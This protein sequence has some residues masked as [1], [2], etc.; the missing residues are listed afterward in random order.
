[1]NIKHLI[2]VEKWTLVLS[3]LLVAVAVLV[4][5]RRAAFGISIG[6]GLMSLNA[7]ALRRIGQRAFKTFK[8]PNVAILLLNVKMGI[9][10]ALVWA[11]IH[12]LRVDPVAFIV[13][14]SVFPV[15]MVVTAVRHALRK[16]SDEEQ[17]G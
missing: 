2:A 11:I 3:A 10:I 4:L 12:Y 1:M 7:Y 14:I 16:E 8:R 15:A 9:L 5:G 13:G 17:H 6:A